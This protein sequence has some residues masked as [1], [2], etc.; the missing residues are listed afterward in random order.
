MATDPNAY[1]AF[2]KTVEAEVPLNERLLRVTFDEKRIRDSAGLPAVPVAFVAEAGR[3]LRVFDIRE[4]DELTG[5]LGH[6]PGISRWPLSQLST[7]AGAV[8]RDSPVVL[9]SNHTDRAGKAAQY[10]ELLGMTRVAA[11]DGGMTAW[12][13]SGLTISRDQTVLAREMRLEP[14]PETVPP[15]PITRERVEQHIAHSGTVRWVKMAAFLLHG[16]RS[17]ID[18]RDDHGVIGTPGGDMGEFLLALTGWEAVT[19]EQLKP[20]EIQHWLR[21]YVDTFGRFY[22]HTDVNTVQKLVPAVRADPRLTAHV[23]HLNSPLEWRQWI[24]KPPAE[25]HDALIGHYRNPEHVGCGHV[26]LSIRFPEKYGAR[27]GLAAD[28]LEAFWRV[29]WEGHPEL[30]YVLLGGDHQEKAV[31]AV[32]IAEQPWSFSRLPMVSPMIDGEQVFIYHPQVM[33]LMREQLAEFL[34]RSAKRPELKEALTAKLIALGNVQAGASLEVLAKG[35]PH[36]E[37]RFAPD[38]VQVR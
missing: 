36:F 11:M 13:A 20:A 26:K 1:D 12:R 4:P 2:P 19:G 29:R 14:A 5:P 38:G 35:L 34:T 18:G 8:H 27:A 21:Q 3:R 7:L 30:E 17:C 9:I 23:A 16:M 22:L 6:V 25:L 33:Q 37:V 10:L 32:T 24:K 31:V 15:G 28:A